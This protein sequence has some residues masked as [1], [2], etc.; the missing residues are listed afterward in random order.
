MHERTYAWLKMFRRKRTVVP[1]KEYPAL[2]QEV[3]PK[4]AEIKVRSQ[5]DAKTA[6]GSL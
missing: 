1:L 4:K 6:L 2:C 3:G 5:G